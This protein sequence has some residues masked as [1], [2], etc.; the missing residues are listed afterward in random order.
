MFAFETLHRYVFIWFL[1]SFMRGLNKTRKLAA[2]LRKGFRSLNKA[3]VFNSKTK[4]LFNG[5]GK[6]LLGREKW[7][8]SRQLARQCWRYVN[9][10]SRINSSS[11]AETFSC[12]L[13]EELSDQNNTVSSKFIPVDVVTFSHIKARKHVFHY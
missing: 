11:D 4:G 1:K 12:A 3:T 7:S 5:A 13:A 9:S 10:H 2:S 6:A 8:W